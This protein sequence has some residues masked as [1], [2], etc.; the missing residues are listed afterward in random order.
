MV[1][2]SFREEDL[3]GWLWSLSQSEK[4][5][6]AIDCGRFLV[7]RRR[8]GRLI[9]DAFSVRDDGM[10]GQSKDGSW[11]EPMGFGAYRRIEG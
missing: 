8:F 5:I 3:G 4:K 11:S 7:Q 2:F 10:G 6:W 9:V 1:V